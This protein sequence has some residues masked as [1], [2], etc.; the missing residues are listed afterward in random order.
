MLLCQNQHNVLF[1]ENWDMAF[2]F[3]TIF[4]YFPFFLKENDQFLNENIIF[5]LKVKKKKKNKH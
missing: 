4:I 1:D 2:C 3:Q 5:G